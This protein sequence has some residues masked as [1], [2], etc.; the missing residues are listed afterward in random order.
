MIKSYFRTFNPF[1][2]S[3]S[4]HRCIHEVAKIGFG[5]EVLNYEKARPS[6]PSEVLKLAEEIFEFNKRGSEK[7]E[8]L[9]LAAGTGK[10]TRLLATNNNLN[11]SAVE[12][13]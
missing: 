1:K 2:Y 12:R 8:V 6:Y 11:I 7:H 9:D 10:F 3:S 5:K 4:Q 13:K